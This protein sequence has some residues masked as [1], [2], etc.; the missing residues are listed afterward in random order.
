MANEL[1][2]WVKWQLIVWLARRLPD[3]K[4]ITRQLGESLDQ[5]KTWREKLVMRLHVFTCEA[6]D[7]YLEQV[8][9]LRDAVRS[10]GDRDP[11]IAEFSTATL[12]PESKAQMK[13]I[14]RQR[15]GLVF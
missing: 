5:K 6:C 11:D 12:S 1:F 15:I 2:Q 9:F 8:A 10:H 7:R 14:L 3:C 13:A 4:Q